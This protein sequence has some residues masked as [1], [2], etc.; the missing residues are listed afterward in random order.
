MSKGLNLLKDNIVFADEISSMV[1]V[2]M[3]V[4]GTDKSFVK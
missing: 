4:F 2:L 3:L 1:K